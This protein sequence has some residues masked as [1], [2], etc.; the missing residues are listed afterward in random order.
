[1]TLRGERKP[2]QALQLQNELS[3]APRPQLGRGTPCSRPTVALPPAQS[4]G[5]SFLG[6]GHSALKLCQSNCRPDATGLTLGQPG[7]AQC[8]RRPLAWC[9]QNVRPRRGRADSAL[10]GWHPLSPSKRP[11]PQ[12]PSREGTVAEAVNTNSRGLAGTLPRRTIGAEQVGS[13]VYFTPA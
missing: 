4:P 7:Q 12:S 13:W 6:A 3:G 1:M 11:A 10:R 9:R 2:S 8:A 5:A